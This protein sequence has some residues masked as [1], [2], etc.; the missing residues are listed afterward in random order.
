MAGF[1]LPKFGKKYQFF[2]S[3]ASNDEIVS[4]SKELSDEMA[5][6]SE[7]LMRSSSVLLATSLFAT[8][9]LLFLMLLRLEESTAYDTP[10]MFIRIGA[11]AMLFIATAM[12]S[13]ALK[14]AIGVSSSSPMMWR[15]IRETA[16]DDAAYEQIAAINKA[17]KLLFI[18]RNN[19]NM[20]STMLVVGSMIAILTY[21]F[22]MIVSAGYI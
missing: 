1:K 7:S 10:V 20:A 2:L 13:S 12:S 14:M 4:I 11:M 22:V 16:N 8:F 21:L 17:N 9:M 15:N 3:E 6:Q 19:L 18:G 5:A